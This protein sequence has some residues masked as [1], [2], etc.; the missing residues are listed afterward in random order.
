[1]DPRRFDALTRSLA[2]PRSR[3]G[4]LGGLVALVAGLG[5]GRVVRPESAAAQVNSTCA[6]LRALFTPYG[7]GCVATPTDLYVCTAVWRPYLET[8]GCCMDAPTTTTTVAPT[9][10]TTTVAPTTTTTAA[11][12]T[13]TTTPVTQATC[14]NVVCYNRTTQTVDVAC[15][16]GCVCCVYGNGNSRCMPPGSCTGVVA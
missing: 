16:P 11:P 6:N 2:T 8:F 12:T 9:T 13:T 5:G 14:G 1:M 7:C 4:F 15:N 10:T 3:R